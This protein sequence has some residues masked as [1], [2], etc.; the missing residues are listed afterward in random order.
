[1]SI[2]TSDGNG[3]EIKTMPELGQWNIVIG[4]AT[5]NEAAARSNASSAA[6]LLCRAACCGANVFSCLNIHVKN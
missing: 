5:S 4:Y 6:A 3:K 1:M 2:Y